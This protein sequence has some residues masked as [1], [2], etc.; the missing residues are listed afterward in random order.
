MSKILIVGAGAMGSAFTFPCVDNGHSVT[1]IGSPL[2]DKLIDKLNRSKR[3]H[4]TLD[5]YLPKKLKLF[6][7]NKLFESFKSKPNLVVIGVNSMGIE[8]IGKIL[9]KFHNPNVPIILLTKGLTIFHK[10]IEPLSY[11]LL[12]IIKKD[13]FSKFKNLSITSVAGPCIAKSLAKRKM[14]SVVFSN[15]FLENAKKYKKIFETNYYKI[16]CSKYHKSVQ[17]CAA[18]KNFYS[19]IIGSVTDLNTAS[20]IFYKSFLEMSKFI[21]LYGGNEKTAHGLAGLADLHV[22]SAGGRNSKMGKYLGDGY[23]YKKAKLKFMKHETVEGADLAFELGPKILNKYHKKNFPLIH[24][25]VES[26]CLNKKLKLKN[27]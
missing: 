6:K 24:S 18:I 2:E 7:A 9:A 14:T 12:S 22:S 3:F 13:Q 19:M 11:K 23:T 4:K 25:L 10:R 17:Y 1:L 21:K 20:V 5:C 27:Y 16:E 8:W 15:E 26:I